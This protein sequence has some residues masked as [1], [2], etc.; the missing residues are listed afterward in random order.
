MYKQVVTHNRRAAIVFLID[1]SLSMMQQT[2]I[3]TL[4]C[5]KM[6]MAEIICNLMIDELVIRAERHGSV[7]NYYDIAALGY[8]NYGVVSLLPGNTEGFMPVDRLI[9]LMPMPKTILNH[10]TIEGT[11]VE[12][13]ISYHTWVTPK[14][15]GTSPMLEAL[16]HTYMI[17]D[18]WCHNLDNRDSFPPIIFHIT[19]GAGN[20]SN[21]AALIDMASRI[22]STHTNDGN[23]LLFNVQLSSD[24]DDKQVVFP[25]NRRFTTTNLDSML[26]FKMSS[27]IPK[28]LESSVS[29]LLNLNRRGPY[30]GM[31]SNYSPCDLT[32]LINTGTESANS[33]KHM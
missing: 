5:S 27:V 18:E 30:R 29:Y 20:D 3:G 12:I 4:T 6:E 22:M 26:L 14:A 9:E 8:S 32:S 15:G 16:A 31:M 23:T 11:E 2:R 19:D 24:A 28:S 17:V 25:N 7:R 13:P 1:C 33:I 10:T 21:S